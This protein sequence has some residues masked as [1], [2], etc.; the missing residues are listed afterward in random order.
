ME[1]RHGVTARTSTNGTWSRAMAR[2]QR[3]RGTAGLN[4]ASLRIAR[5]REDQMPGPMWVLAGRAHVQVID[6]FEGWKSGTRTPGSH[7]VTHDF[8]HADA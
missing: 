3:D 4:A 7:P 6:L 1:V 8:Q 2:H 5:P